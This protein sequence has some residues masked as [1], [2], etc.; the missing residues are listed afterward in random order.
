[1]ARVSA[2]EGELYYYD[3]ILAWVRIIQQKHLL[4]KAVL[5][6]CG[7]N[8]FAENNE[9]LYSTASTNDV[10]VRDV[11]VWVD[12]GS[13]P[14]EDN[15][16]ECMISTH[17]TEPGNSIDSLAELVRTIVPGGYLLIFYFCPY[18]L[19]GA[20]KLMSKATDLYPSLTTSFAL[21]R[22]LSKLSIEIVEENA[23]SFRP[24]VFKKKFVDLLY[25]EILG[26]T[27]LPCFSSC[28][29]MLVRKIVDADI[30]AYGGCV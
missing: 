7:V 30:Y 23:V 24:M 25:L 18:S 5:L 29:F 26:A 19:V 27:I 3:M 13:L 12:Y 16:I 22:A 1:M 21:K 10:F 15:S 11:D 2:F 6:G 17:L 28:S 14:F 20:Q 9:F 8:E 4:N